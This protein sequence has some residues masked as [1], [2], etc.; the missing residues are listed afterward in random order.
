MVTGAF[1]YRIWKQTIDAAG[2]LA[3]SPPRYDQYRVAEFCLEERRLLGHP[4][5]V[6][7]VGFYLRRERIGAWH[8]SSQKM[9]KTIPTWRS[10]A[11]R[12]IAASDRSQLRS[13]ALSDRGKNIHKHDRDPTTG[14]IGCCARAASGQAAAPAPSREIN[15]RL[16]SR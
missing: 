2:L 4:N 5:L 8:L 9:T 15:F 14:I 1:S 7:R 16:L 12:A 10:T 6:W 13:L 11:R 3:S